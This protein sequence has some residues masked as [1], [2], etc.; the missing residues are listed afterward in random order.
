[1]NIGQ[2]ILRGSSTVFKCP[3][4]TYSYSLQLIN[5]GAKYLRFHS[6]EIKEVI[7]EKDFSKEKA[8]EPQS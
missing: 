2:L 1:M 5:G 7:V 6:A 3:M 4:A 8:D